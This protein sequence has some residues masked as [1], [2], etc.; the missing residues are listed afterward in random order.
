MEEFIENIR[1]VLGS[2]GHRILESI[3]SKVTLSNT[4]EET[5]G[6]YDFIFSVNKLI[7][8]GKVTDD[9][10][11]LLEGSQVAHKSNPS[12]PSKSNQIKEQMLSDEVLEDKGDHY[13]LLK[14]KLISSS[15]YAA[16]LVA[17]GSRSG[18]Q[19]WKTPKGDLLKAVEERLVNKT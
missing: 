1:N 12:M 9:G 19:S 7:A 15:S 2:L 17:G 10:F 11:L 5:L 16:A 6:N 18:P 4:N 13:L 3:T 8:K 14:N